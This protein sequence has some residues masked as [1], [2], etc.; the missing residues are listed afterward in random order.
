MAKLLVTIDYID[1]RSVVK[2]PLYPDEI[3]TNGMLFRL[4][5]RGI[6]SITFAN[7]EPLSEK[8]IELLEG[9]K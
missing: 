7:A 3:N 5:E 6:A 2:G 1:G 8:N 9:K 4:S